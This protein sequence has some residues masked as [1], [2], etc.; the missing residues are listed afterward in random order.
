MYLRNYHFWSNS[1]RISHLKHLRIISLILFYAS[2][3]MG[4][5]V[6]YHFCCEEFQ[7]LTVY[8]TPGDCCGNDCPGCNNTSYELIIASD[9][10]TQAVFSFTEMQVLSII[11]QC[12]GFSTLLPQQTVQ[13]IIAV[14]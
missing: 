10:D 6:N 9:Y 4:M 12:L 8:I 7:Y 14:D 13:E 5:L 2:F 11:Q 1:R 3:N